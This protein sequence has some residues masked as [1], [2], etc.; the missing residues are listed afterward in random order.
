MG[1]HLLTSYTF[2]LK[3]CLAGYEDAS[4]MWPNGSLS[5][6]VVGVK[7]ALLLFAYCILFALKAVDIFTDYH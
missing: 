3:Q 5:E 2:D 1:F 4:Q 6:E 7:W